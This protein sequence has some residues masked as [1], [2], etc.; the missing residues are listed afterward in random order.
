MWY[1]VE[2][3]ASALKDFIFFLDFYWQSHEVY[4]KIL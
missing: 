1:E 4:I 3:I 2:L